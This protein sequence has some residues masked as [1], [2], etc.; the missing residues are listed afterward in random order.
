MASRVWGTVAG[1]IGGSRDIEWVEDD[2]KR[3]LMLVKKDW[4]TSGGLIKNIYATCGGHLPFL[5]PFLFFFLFF[6]P[7]FF[8][9]F[10]LFPLFFLPF[11]FPFFFEQDHF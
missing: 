8:L 5:F 10:F 1:D 4:S 6:L 2:A 7:P 11:L 9:F 3:A